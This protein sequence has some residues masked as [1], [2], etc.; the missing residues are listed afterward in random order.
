MIVKGKM[1]HRT[2]WGASAQALSF[3]R[4]I[5]G[6]PGERPQLTA[7]SGDEACH[8]VCAIATCIGISTRRPQWRGGRYLRDQ[9]PIGPSCSFAA[10]TWRDPFLYVVPSPIQR[11]TG[12]CRRIAD[13]LSGRGS[14]SIQSLP[15]TSRRLLTFAASEANEKGRQRHCCCDRPHKDGSS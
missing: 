3:C 14:R 13:H 5:G 12:R 1:T 10:G 6:R 11:P 8:R 7:S 2:R 9:L 15:S 4:G